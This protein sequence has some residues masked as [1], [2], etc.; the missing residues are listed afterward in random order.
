MKRKTHTR[1][2]LAVIER[3]ATRRCD[4]CRWWERSPFQVTGG[5][6]VAE[7]PDSPMWASEITA[8]RH[9]IYTMADHYCAA[10]T[11]KENS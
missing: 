8:A 9:R 2:Q 10:H 1:D 4:G 7:L 5:C 6:G 3:L 11:P